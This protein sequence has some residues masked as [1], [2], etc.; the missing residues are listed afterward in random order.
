M[1][2]LFAAVMTVAAV[3]VAPTATGADGAALDCTG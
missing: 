1:A 2:M 3:P